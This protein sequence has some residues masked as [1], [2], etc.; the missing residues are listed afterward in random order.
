MDEITHHLINPGLML[1]VVCANK[2]DGFHSPGDRFVR[3]S[4]CR[5]AVLGITSCAPEDETWIQHF[6][7]G[8]KSMLRQHLA[9]GLRRAGGH[10][11][12]ECDM[13]ALLWLWVKTSST[14]LGVGEFTHPLE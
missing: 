6:N 10:C 3:S 8:D 4:G 1:P 9:M 13:T 11:C 2:R 7:M 14:M 12:V 5:V